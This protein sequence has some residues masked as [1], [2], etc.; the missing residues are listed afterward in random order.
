VQGR[1]GWPAARQGSIEASPGRRIGRTVRPGP[2]RCQRR[3]PSP[4]TSLRGQPPLGRWRGW[5]VGLRRR[6][7]GGAQGVYSRRRCGKIPCAFPSMLPLLSSPLEYVFSPS[8][9]RRCVTWL[10]LVW[11][12]PV[13]LGPIVA[14]DLLSVRAPTPVTRCSLR[15][16]TRAGRPVGGDPLYTT[17]CFACPDMQPVA[18]TSTKA[19][20]DAAP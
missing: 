19:R 5:G 8:C 18:S 12:L 11:W 14:N 15:L 16:A 2:P 10:R 13:A 3:R 1:A 17:A 6:S 4:H 7:S 9:F 20:G